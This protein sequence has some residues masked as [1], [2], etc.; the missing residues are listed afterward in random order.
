[1]PTEEQILRLLSYTGPSIGSQLATKINE[2]SL[3][4]SA[5]L[6]DLVRRDKIKISKFKTAS[7]PF[8]YLKGQEEMLVQLTIKEMNHKDRPTLIRLQE[9]GVLQ[10]NEMDLLGRV[11]IRKYPDLAIPMQVTIEGTPI[12]Y[13]RWFQ[14]ESDTFTKL[15]TDKFTPEESEPAKEPEPVKESEENQNVEAVHNTDTK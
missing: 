6:S 14:I 10:D 15:I 9:N 1:M 2:D 4:T 13:W 3:L 7:G 8:Y 11:S 12:L 5:F